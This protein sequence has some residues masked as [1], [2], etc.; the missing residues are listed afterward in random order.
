MEQDNTLVEKLKLLDEGL[1]KELNQY[2]DIKGIVEGN[3]YVQI[4]TE[5]TG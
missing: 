2:K 4:L 1:R 3:D 5:I